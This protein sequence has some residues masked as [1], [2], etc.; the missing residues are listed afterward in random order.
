MNVLHLTTMPLWPVNNGARLRTWNLL[1]H[2]AAKH[3]GTLL[4]MYTHADAPSENDREQMAS[5]VPDVRL[6]PRPTHK[7][8]RIANGIR[9][10]A[11]GDA[12]TYLNFRFSAFAQAIE[13]IL[14]EKDF[15]LVHCHQNHTLLYRHL[16]ADKAILLDSHG[17]GATQWRAYGGN[18]GNNLLVRAFCLYQARLLDRLEGDMNNGCDAV[19]TCSELEMKSLQEKCPDVPYF[20]IPNGV[21]TEYFSSPPVEEEPF[22]LVY[23]SAFDY[24]PN[25]DAVVQFVQKTLPII[26]RKYPETKLYL[27]GKDPVPAVKAL[28]SSHVIVTGTVDDVR[29]DVAKAQVFV[30]PLRVGQGTR[31]KVVEAMSMSKAIVSTSVGAEGI[32]YTHDENILIADTPQE[33][34]EAV[35]H[36]FEDSGRR[37]R[38]GRA[39][40]ELAV[41]RYDW[42]LWGTA[43]DDAY[44]MALDRWKR[45]VIP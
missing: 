19:L 24:V 1:K 9:S 43:M 45:R 16:F 21:D 36:L 44:A 11:T 4:A 17:L 41:Q 18:K 31:L 10:L 2:V 7:A 29:P 6:I 34:A 38:L 25:A 20:F 35:G 15:D 40:R 42:G 14:E 33:M 5:L 32:Q 39:A 12:F 3:T 23:T 26:L 37:Q 30:V 13:K 22:S 28:A 8:F 27:V